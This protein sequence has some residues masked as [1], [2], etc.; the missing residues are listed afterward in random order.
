V[1]ANILFDLRNRL[2]G[3]ARFRRVAQKTPIFQ[4]VARKRAR[5]LFRLCSGFI[6]SQ[7]LLACVRLGL[8]ERLREG[9]Q[10]VAAIARETGIPECR[11]HQLLRAADALALLE[12]RPDGRYGLGVLGAAMTDN[13]SLIALVEHHALFYEDLADPVALFADPGRETRMARLWPYASGPDAASLEASD[14]APYTDL[15][16]ASQEMVAEQVLEAFSFRN[17]RRL[18]DIGGGAGAFAIAVARRWPKLRITIADLPAVADIARRRVDDAGLA[19]RIDV[20][21]ADATADSLPGGFDAVSLVRI[22]HDHDEKTVLKLLAAAK[23]AVREG[24]TLLVAEPM[25]DAPGA[26]NLNAAYFNVYLM[27]MGSGRPRRFDELAELVTAAGF[28]DVRRRRTPVPLIT[29][30]LVARA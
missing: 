11:A 8:F 16:A 6:H 22:L 2:L 19:S 25:A 26:G 17:Q 24:G 13:T 4:W 14:V 7:V 18:L 3:S 10:T 5:E 28:R 30:V 1:P 9:A 20:V 29:G 15:M 12:E 21:G 23:S 27:A